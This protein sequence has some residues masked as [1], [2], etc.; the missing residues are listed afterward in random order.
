[1]LIELEAEPDSDADIRLGQFCGGEFLCDECEYGY[2][3]DYKTCPCCELTR[4]LGCNGGNNYYACSAC[5]NKSVCSEC[6]WLEGDKSSLLYFCD[7]CAHSDVDGCLGSLASSSSNKGPA[8]N[9]ERVN[10]KR[11]KLM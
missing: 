4:C 6:V 5:D 8:E 3:F 9:Q 10:S 7:E 11:P 1:M 2:D